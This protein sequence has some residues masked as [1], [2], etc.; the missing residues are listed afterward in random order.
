LIT[1][2]GQSTYMATRGY[3]VADNIDIFP[4]G[5]ALLLDGN[6]LVVAD[7]H[8]GYEASL[9]QE[10]LS[11]PRVQTK[12]IED[13]LL[14]TIDALAP[15][16]VVVAGDLKHNFSM[17]LTQ[18]WQDV[19]RF[20]RALAGRASLDVVRG[21]HDNYL[22]SI[23]REHHIP[24]VRD[25]TYSGVRVVHGHEGVLT[26]DMTVMGHLHPSIR[27]R[28]SIGASLKDPCFLFDKA[29]RVLVLPALSLVSPGMDVV[30]QDWSDNISPLLS[31]DGLSSCVPIAFSGDRALEFPTIGE[32]RGLRSRD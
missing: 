16:K 2:T 7:M 25:A 3:R 11:I 29:R 27:L 18:E 8:L 31:C 1:V 5:A 13:Y 20:V 9:E 23:L 30:G 28:D 14:R 19:A 32:L 17:N 10:G 6:I 21:N 22:G 4:G 12:K 24:L 26:G 15:E